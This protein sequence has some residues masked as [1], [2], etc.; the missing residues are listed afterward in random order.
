MVSVGAT[1]VEMVIVIE[2]DVAVVGDA[3]ASLDVST[4]VTDW[5]LVRVVVVKLAL[6]VP[7]FVPFTFH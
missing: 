3:Q 1:D 2:L 6:F 5:P 4:Q 7:T